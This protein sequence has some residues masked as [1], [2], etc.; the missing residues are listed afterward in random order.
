MYCVYWIRQAKHTDPFAEGYIGI[1][2]NLDERLR[3]HKNNKRKTPFTNAIK[4][5]GWDNLVVEVLHKSLSQQEALTL[6]ETFRPTQRIGWNC[7]KGG[8]LGVE[9]SWYEIEEHRNKH[10][11]ATALATREAIRLKDSPTARSERAKL[12]WARNRDS[13]EG[14]SKGS[15]NPRAKL[16]EEQVRKIKYE[17]L[18]NNVPIKEIADQFNVK[19]HVIN[20]IKQGK[21]W[22]HI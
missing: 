10:R 19:P 6:E 13:Y 2:I 4:K 16:N 21:N 11:E 8:E 18:P 1:T 5:Y 12:S 7:Q 3:H 17:M 9:R 14:V 22:S 15:S 20:F